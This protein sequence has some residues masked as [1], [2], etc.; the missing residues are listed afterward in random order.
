MPEFQ[1]HHFKE[2]I[3]KLGEHLKAS[4]HGKLIK[5]IQPGWHYAVAGTTQ[6]KWGC[7]GFG[8]NIEL[9][10]HNKITPEVMSEIENT[11]KQFSKEHLAEYGKTISTSKAVLEQEMD[12]LYAI[13]LKIS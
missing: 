10:A 7:E 4:E 3:Q 13:N 2:Y 9:K 8:A 6:M 1:E 11:I 12:R 5:E